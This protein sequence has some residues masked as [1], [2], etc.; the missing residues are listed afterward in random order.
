MKTEGV[1]FEDVETMYISGGFSAKIN[2]TNAVDSGLLPKEM[3]GKTVSLNNSSLLGTVKY[4]CEGGELG[5]LTD[6]IRYVDL[7]AN[8]YFSD[9]FMQNMTFE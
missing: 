7:S 1:R 9:L 6:R 3:R 8:P 5:Q 2:I 4:A